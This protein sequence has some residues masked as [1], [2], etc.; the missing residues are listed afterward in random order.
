MKTLT[1]MTIKAVK[2]FEA[3][4][5][6]LSNKFEGAEV[7]LTKI[8]PAEWE[9]D[10]AGFEAEFSVNGQYSKDYQL[11]VT[12]NNSTNEVVIT[13]SVDSNLDF[14]YFAHCIEVGD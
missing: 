6:E 4:Q 14:G 1:Q 7:L 2:G 8:C 5:E 13:L 11:W 12:V 9:G 10:Y 3:I